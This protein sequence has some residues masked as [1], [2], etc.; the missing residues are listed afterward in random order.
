MLRIEDVR[1]MTVNRQ[2]FS[3]LFTDK[4]TG[5]STRLAITLH[6]HLAMLANYANKSLVNVGLVA[7]D[8]ACPV[9]RSE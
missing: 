4:T 2:V 6:S 1:G 9:E 5:S 7:G 8:A 3:P